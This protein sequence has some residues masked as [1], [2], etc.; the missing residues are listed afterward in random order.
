[1][2]GT[3]NSVTLT[4]LLV[5]LAVNALL[6]SLFLVPL[7]RRSKLSP[8]VREVAVRNLM[9]VQACHFVGFQLMRGL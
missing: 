4:V 9:Y 2:I 8:Q 1:M 3:Q 6:T 7:M 5:D